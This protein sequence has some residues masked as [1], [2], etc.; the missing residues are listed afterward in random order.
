MEKKFTDKNTKAQ[1]LEG[2]RELFDKYKD[3]KSKH[4]TTKDAMMEQSNNELVDRVDA[5]EFTDLGTYI[6]HIESIQKSIKESIDNYEDL[7]R[8]IDVKNNELE[9]LLGIEKGAFSLIALKEA[10]EIEEKEHNDYLDQIR[11]KKTAQLQDQIDLLNKN[12]EELEKNFKRRE[13]ELKYN[14]ARERKLQQDS[15]DDLSAQKDKEY[16]QQLAMI[17]TMKID[18][19]QREKEIEAKLEDIKLQHQKELAVIT[20]S[21]KSKYEN[22]LK[23]L[24]TT[25]NSEKAQLEFKFN[26]NQDKVAELQA[27]NSRLSLKLDEAYSKLETLAKETVQGAQ[28][29]SMIKELSTLAKNNKKD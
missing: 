20:N 26:V 16:E 10:Q 4:S 15:I 14:F 17:D 19:E 23:L 22:E 7:K 5:T 8:A 29:D 25:T 2:Y 28:K 21:L 6:K 12:I 13:E 27:E 1:I 11:L 3:L 9:E 18:I 24:E